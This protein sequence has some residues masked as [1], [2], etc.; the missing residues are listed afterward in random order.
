MAMAPEGSDG[1]NTKPHRITASKAWCFTLNNYDDNDINQLIDVL[2]LHKYFFAKETGESGTPHLQGFVE[3]N[4]KCRPLEMIKNKKIHWE[5]MKGKIEQNIAYCSKEEGTFFCKGFKPIKPIKIIT[6]LYPFQKEVVNIINEEP[7]ERTIYWFWEPNGNLGKSAVVKYLAVK[8]DALVLS[9]KSSDMKY[10]II[11]YKEHYGRYP[12]II[13]L[14]FPRSSEGYI[15][16]TGIEEIKNGC[17]ASTKY[18]CEMVIMNSPHI[19]CFANFPVDTTIMSND[20]WKIKR[21]T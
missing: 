21:I 16:W 4:K 2:A 15:S 1:G 17:F 11:K 6:E 9:G 13:L 10:L 3:F 20:R 12:E 18:D 14:D 19:I 5:K 8:H 7:N